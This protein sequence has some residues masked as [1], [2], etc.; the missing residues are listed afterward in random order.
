MI[1]VGFDVRDVR[2]VSGHASRHSEIKKVGIWKKRP[3]EP[4][5]QD[6]SEYVSLVKVRAGT[7]ATGLG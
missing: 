2:M 7:P 4:R 3:P 1:E 6:V 5:P